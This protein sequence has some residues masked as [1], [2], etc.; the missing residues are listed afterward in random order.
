MSEFILFVLS[1]VG[2]G[3]ATAWFPAQEVLPNV[4]KIRDLRISSEWEQ[5]TQPN[6]PKKKKETEEEIK[7]FLHSECGHSIIIYANYTIIYPN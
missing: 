1:S 7:V 6:H 4:H 3:L 5:A 2:S